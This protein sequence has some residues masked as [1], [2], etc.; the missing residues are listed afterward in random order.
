[1]ISN[2]ASITIQLNQ[3]R[4]TAL[5]RNWFSSR[6]CLCLLPAAAAADGVLPQYLEKNDCKD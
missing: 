2:D 5:L 6:K 4:L 3:L 1:M